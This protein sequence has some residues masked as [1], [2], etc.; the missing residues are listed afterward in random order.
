MFGSLYDANEFCNLSPRHIRLSQKNLVF[1]N[2]S[3]SLG[4]I[5]V[6]IIN[7]EIAFYIVCTSLRT[8]AGIPLIIT[9]CLIIIFYSPL[10]KKKY[11][12]SK[13][14]RTDQDA[15][16]PGTDIFRAPYLPHYYFFEV[17]CS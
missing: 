12:I 15:N 13:R 17:R 8:V 5:R 14:K 4:E 7:L 1:I 10:D 2:K 16:K 11:T 6:F 9:A 3:K